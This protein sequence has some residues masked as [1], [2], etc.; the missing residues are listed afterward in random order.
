MHHT[1]PTQSKLVT[2]FSFRHLPGGRCLNVIYTKPWKGASVNFFVWQFNIQ[3]FMFNASS[4][5]PISSISETHS[6]LH[7]AAKIWIFW[8]CSP[9]KSSFISL[10]DLGIWYQVQYYKKNCAV[11]LKQRHKLCELLRRVEASWAA[12]EHPS[13]IIICTKPRKDSKRHICPKP[14]KVQVF[15]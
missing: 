4:S 7:K 6:S 10:S 2:F 1:V 13:L 14:W 9:Y 12:K 5:K 15:Q 8:S 11:D 3:T